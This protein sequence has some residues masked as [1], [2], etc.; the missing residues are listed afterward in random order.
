MRIATIASMRTTTIRCGL[1]RQAQT[2]AAAAILMAIRKWLITTLIT[3]TVRIIRST[4]T[5]FIIR[6]QWYRPICTH[7]TADLIWTRPIYR[8][9]TWTAWI[10]APHTISNWIA[11]KASATWAFIIWPMICTQ[12]TCKTIITHQSTVRT[13]AST[14]TPAQVA[15]F[16]L[17][18]P[19]HKPSPIPFSTPALSSI[20]TIITCPTINMYINSVSYGDF[21]RITF[22][23]LAE[24][25]DFW[26]CILWKYS[27]FCWKNARFSLKNSQ[28]T[29]FW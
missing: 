8:R 17:M 27:E 28:R 4:G 15:V 2:V 1:I 22:W 29:T 10:S 20:R 19:H 26:R 16:C 14:A 25:Q 12:T 7:K 3:A 13:F 11:S 24:I 23:I 5:H 21:K 6:T 9:S 18:A